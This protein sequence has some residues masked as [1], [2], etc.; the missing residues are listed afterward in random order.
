MTLARYSPLVVA[1]SVCSLPPCGG[2]LG[3]GV[4]R[5]DDGGAACERIALPPPLTPPH[6]G[7]GN[8]PSAWGECTEY[9]ED[10]A[11]STRRSARRTRRRFARCYVRDQRG[12]DPC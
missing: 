10:S 2:G 5:C 11:P 3:R 7:E 8:T 1:I 12:R 6:K 4:M 9:V